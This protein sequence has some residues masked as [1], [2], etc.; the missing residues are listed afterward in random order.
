MSS[1]VNFY[2]IS[3]F[4]NWPVCNIKHRES[5]CLFEKNVFIYIE[6]K[7][8]ISTTISP[9]AKSINI[10]LSLFKQAMLEIKKIF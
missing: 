10:F 4:L 7:G 5:Y 6:M 1:K 9:F 2:E 8:K 3:Q